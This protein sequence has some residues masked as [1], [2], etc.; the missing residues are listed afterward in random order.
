MKATA[1]PRWTYVDCAVFDGEGFLVARARSL[2]D[3]RRLA[4]A[5]NFVE[6]VSTEALEAWTVGIVRD[7]INDLAGE[8]ESLLTAAVPGERRSGDDRRHL[9]RR[10]P[11]T[12][13]GSPAQAS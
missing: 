7:P 2:Q 3:A 6:C 13:A 1:V 9:D 8:L 12:Q 10:R 5:I 4:A 11:A